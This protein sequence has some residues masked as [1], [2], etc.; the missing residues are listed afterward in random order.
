VLYQRTRSHKK[1]SV[2]AALCVTPQRDRVH[3]FFRLH[4]DANIT[5]PLVVEFLRHLLR[6]LRGPVVV[7]WDR[8]LAHRA[9]RVQ[10]LIH[11]NHRLHTQFLPPYAP[12][13][14]PTENVWS[15]LKINPLANLPLSDSESLAQMT[16]RYGRSVQRKQILLRAFLKHTPLFLRLK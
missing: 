10:D 8:L 2:I 16:H 12:D 9:N 3:L 11:Y 4:R 5:A 7:I 15:Y 13:L 6:Q 1:V 14:N